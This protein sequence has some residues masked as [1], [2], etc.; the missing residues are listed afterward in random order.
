MSKYKSVEAPHL[1]DAANEALKLL[2][3]M[4]AKEA[5]FVLLVMGHAVVSKGWQKEH[6]QKEVVEKFAASLKA[7]L[8]LNHSKGGMQ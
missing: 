7:N 4:T 8:S 1:I 2:S 3:D 5:L 6:D